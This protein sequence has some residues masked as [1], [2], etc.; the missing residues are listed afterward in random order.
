VCWAVSGD[1]GHSLG[2]HLS[3]I[4]A[5]QHPH[6]LQG[7][8]HVACGSPYYADFGPGKS[9]LIRFLCR[10]IPLFKLAPGY[11]PGQ[12]LGFA[13]RESL[14]LMNDWRYWARTGR[15]DYGP[16]QGLHA[17]IA[18]FSGALLAVSMEGDELS[19]LQAEKRAIAVFTAARRTEVRLRADASGKPLGHFKWARQPDATVQ[20][21]LQWLESEYPG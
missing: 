21:I 7:V 2:G 3:S 1:G 5:G 17:A 12:L 13:G 15:L 16:H 18:D 8:L 4:F 11:F 14:Q 20:V 6:R 10:L 19:S 9:L